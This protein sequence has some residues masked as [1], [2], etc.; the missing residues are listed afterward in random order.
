MGASPRSALEGQRLL[1]DHH[2]VMLG[3]GAW[4][5]LL[6]IFFVLEMVISR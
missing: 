3:V 5:L 2:H 1:F 4:L 6:F